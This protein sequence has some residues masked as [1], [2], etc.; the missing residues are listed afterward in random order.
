M[1]Y[2][3]AHGSSCAILDL[4]TAEATCK[5]VPVT[6]KDVIVTT[7]EFCQHCIRAGFRYANTMCDVQ[8]CSKPSDDVI[9][10]MQY[11]CYDH[12]FTMRTLLASPPP[13]KVIQ[14]MLQLLMQLCK[15]CLICFLFVL[16]EITNCLPIVIHF[17]TL[18]NA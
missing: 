6:D 1:Q 3:V 18:Q 11:Q 10:W 13:T 16:Q 12:C 4:P 5:D 14:Q 2:V 7:I 15:L 8:S 17:T 9:S